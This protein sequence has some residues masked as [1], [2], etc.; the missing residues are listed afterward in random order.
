MTPITK[1]LP[2]LILLASL[3]NASSEPRSEDQLA[4]MRAQTNDYANGLKADLDDDRYA[5]QHESR[6]DDHLADMKGQTNEYVK[7][8]HNEEYA[9]HL[10]RSLKA[11]YAAGSKEDPSYCGPAGSPVSSCPVQ[12]DI[13]DS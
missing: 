10:E 5:R 3:V 12:P 7:P 4:D 2:L 6:S 13:V 8:E 9:R 1:L 11:E